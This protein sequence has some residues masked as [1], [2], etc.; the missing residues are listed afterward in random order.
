MGATTYFTRHLLT[1]MMTLLHR[2]SRKAI[3]FPPVACLLVVATLGLCTSAMQEKEHEKSRRAKEEKLRTFLAGV[4]R[5]SCATDYVVC[6][7]QLKE[8][9]SPPEIAKLEI[10]M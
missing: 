9:K 3:R 10:K 4:K 8:A 1:M 5:I 7:S 2:N 6:D